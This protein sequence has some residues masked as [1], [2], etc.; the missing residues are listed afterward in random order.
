MGGSVFAEVSFD[1][2]CEMRQVFNSVLYR[3]GLLVNQNK[4]R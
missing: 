1:N 3:T 4:A 2:A